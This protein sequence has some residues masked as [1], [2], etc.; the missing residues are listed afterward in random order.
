MKVERCELSPEE[1][2]SSAQDWFDRQAGL[3]AKALGPS[4]LEHRSWVEHYLKEEL[5][6]RLL[7]LGWRPRK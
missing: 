4:W 7:T 1:I 3:I 5:R 2:R 6:Q